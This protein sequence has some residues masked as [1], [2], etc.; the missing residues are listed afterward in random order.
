MSGQFVGQQDTSATDPFYKVGNG[1]VNVCDLDAPSVPEFVEQLESDSSFDEKEGDAEY[2]VFLRQDDGRIR[3]VV[4]ERDPAR[5][6]MATCRDV[7]QTDDGSL[8]N[9]RTMNC[10]YSRETC[11]EIFLKFKQLDEALTRT[12]NNR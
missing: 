6:G 10:F 11:D 4:V 3:Q 7:V 2:R 1:R 5:H 9:R 12:L 8:H